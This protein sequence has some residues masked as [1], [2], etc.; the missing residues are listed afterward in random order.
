MATAG[1]TRD[2]LGRLQ[3]HYMP[4]SGPAGGVFLGE[5]GLNNGYNTQARCDAVHVGFTS[6]SGRVLRGHELKVS[7]ADWLHELRRLDKASVWADACHEWWLV[8]PEAGIVHEGELPPGWGHM[9][10]GRGRRFTVLVAATRKPD[11]HQPS[12]LVTRSVLARMDTLVTQER[13]TMRNDV[14]TTVRAEFQQ[15]HEQLQQVQAARLSDDAQRRLEALDR[16]EAALGA[17]LDTFLPDRT[18]ITP[19]RFAAALQ[20]AAAREALTSQWGA[21][22]SAS[23]QLQAAVDLLN[24]IRD[25]LAELDG[26]PT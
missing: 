15:R 9:I 3:R 18:L 14:T 6:T 8:T 26:N 4:P 5:C 11:D 21:A 22:A 23:H 16:V 17:R 12:W 13:A 1:A 2:L 24:K 10:P 19:G 25:A 20:L 7:R